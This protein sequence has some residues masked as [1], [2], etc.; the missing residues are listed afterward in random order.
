MSRSVLAGLIT[1]TLMTVTAAP[2]LADQIQTQHQTTVDYS[3]I[4]VESRAGAKLV[5]SRIQ[6]AAEKVCGVR[7]GM[8][9]LEEIRMERR[10][11]DDAVEKAIESV[12]TTQERRAALDAARG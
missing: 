12:G 11:V 6:S 10:C 9:S 7:N 4:D 1:A 8:K 5:L 2:A 3:G